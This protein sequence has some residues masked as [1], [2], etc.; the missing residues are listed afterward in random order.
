[1]TIRVKLTLLYGLLFMAAGLAL[2]GISY[3]LVARRM[4]AAEVAQVSGKD[5]TLRAAKM[6]A[7]PDFSPADRAALKTLSTMPPDQTLTALKTG[8]VE[9]SP[10]TQRQL[11]AVLPVTVRADALHQ[12]LVQSA[13]ALSV[14]AVVSLVLGWFVAGRVLRPLARITDMARRLSASNL[15]SRI[16]LDGPNDE[17][18][19][20][21]RTFDEMLDRLAAAFEGQRRFVANAS[22]E[23][24]TPLA[25]MAAEIDVTVAR[26]DASVA[27]LRSMAATVRAAVDRSDRIIASMLTL[28]SVERGLETATPTDLAEVVSGA[29]ERQAAALEAAGIDV[30]ASLSAAKVVGDPAL[31]DRLVDNLVDNG[32][33]HNVAGGW[34]RLATRPV[35]AHVELE[36]ASSGAVV[37]DA[38]LESLFLP[39]R[40]ADRRTA[41]GRGIGL[42]L[43]IVLAIAQAH[44][45][46]ATATPVPG[47]GLRV[48]VEFPADPEGIAPGPPVDAVVAAQPRRGIGPAHSAA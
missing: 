12:L 18:T 48:V 32:I 1:M 30:T 28:A 11:T 6:A 42:G 38:A 33:R 36:V 19:V 45:G 15:E 46:S 10:E 34:L 25:I 14:M 5:V 44:G 23:L 35:G 41:R 27:E 7:D 26:P 20:L 31:L 39:F 37:A 3:Q 29:W 4:P 13:W 8:A 21:A 24:R 40:R 22:H 9:L 43:S 2:V 16:D 47:G 17:L